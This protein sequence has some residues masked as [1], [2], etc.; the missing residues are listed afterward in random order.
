M[1]P[2]IDSANGTPHVWHEIDD[3]YHKVLELVYEKDDVRKAAPFAIRLLRLL[4]KHDPKAETLLGMSGRWLIAEMD[5]DLEETIRYREKELAILRHH[6]DK[7]ILSRSGLE[8]DDFSDRLDMLASDY[9]DVGRYEDA[10]AAL[11]ESEDFCKVHGIPF[12][13]KSIR[14]DVKRAMRRKKEHPEKAS[15]R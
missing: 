4:D 2:A 5:G 12:D 7:G 1:N 3:L 8:A 15:S 6:I 9:L 13:G 11:A 14:D 10:L